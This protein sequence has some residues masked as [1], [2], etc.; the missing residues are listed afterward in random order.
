MKNKIAVAVTS[1]EIESWSNT[2]TANHKTIA[3]NNL[4]LKLVD[5]PK[6]RS[7]EKMPYEGKKIILYEKSLQFTKNN[8]YNI[9]LIEFFLIKPS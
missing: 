5:V 3:P 1:G 4:F 8:Y 7:S 2:S 9:F 6:V